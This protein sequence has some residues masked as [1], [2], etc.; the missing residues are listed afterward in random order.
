M[1][2][3]TLITLLP[4]LTASLSPMSV[5]AAAVAYAN[6]S[7][8]I[9]APPVAVS[10]PESI[11]MSQISQKASSD[12]SISLSTAAAGDDPKFHIKSGGSLTY[13]MAVSSRVNVT[14]KAGNTIL[15]NNFSLPL[16]SDY[17]TSEAAH[18]LRMKADIEK[19]SESKSGPYTGEIFMTANFN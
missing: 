10:M 2:I 17:V 14:N 11:M 6:V 13:S 15:I 8:N 1:K 12:K 16:S 3:K 4:L 19:N 7:A 5:N 18:E 9:V